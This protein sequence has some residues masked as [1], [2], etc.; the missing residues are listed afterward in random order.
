MKT[1][2][3]TSWS[4]SAIFLP[5]FS[6]FIFSVLCDSG[7]Q[8]LTGRMVWLMWHIWSSVGGWKQCFLS[9][10]VSVRSSALLHMQECQSLIC[11]CLRICPWIGGIRHLFVDPSESLVWR[12]R[13]P[14]DGLIQCKYSPSSAYLLLPAA[15]VLWA[16]P[17]SLWAFQNTVNH[18]SHLNINSVGF[19]SISNIFPFAL[20]AVKRHVEYK[21]LQC[22]Q[23]V[24]SKIQSLHQLIVKVWVHP[25]LFLPKYNMKT[26]HTHYTTFPK[27]G[28]CKYDDKYPAANSRTTPLWTERK[29]QQKRGWISL[30]CSYIY[31]CSMKIFMD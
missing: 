3:K 30:F 17:A 15:A 24:F 23:F 22:F 14:T 31:I 9:T 16:D 28:W 29:S 7:I 10:T 11:G 19:F 25:D 4:L 27:Q 12:G 18:F 26:I 13:C 8:R 21:M 6:F 20:L 2:S 1:R 5:Y